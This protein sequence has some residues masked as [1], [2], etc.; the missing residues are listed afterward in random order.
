MREHE[1]DNTEQPAIVLLQPRHRA[2]PQAQPPAQGEKKKK[3][4]TRWDAIAHHA[5][6]EIMLEEFAAHNRP[7]RVL[8]SIGYA[9]LKTLKLNASRLGRDPKTGTIAA[10]EEWWNEKIE[11]MSGCKKFML[12]PLE[13]EDELDIIFEMSTCTN[14]SARVVGRDDQNWSGSVEDKFGDMTVRKEIAEMLDSV[15]EAGVEEGSDELFYATQ[16]P[17]QKEYQDVFATLKKPEVKLA[18]L[19]RTWEERKQH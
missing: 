6:I 5:W 9:N 18:W 19:K 2:R 14:E 1:H 12:G 15:I 7:Q 8:N 13:H 10:S 4:T 11:A 17:I 3:V 16:L